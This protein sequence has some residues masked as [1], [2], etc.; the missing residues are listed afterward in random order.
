MSLLFF[1][2]LDGMQ[3]QLGVSGVGLAIERSQLSLSCPRMHLSSGH[4]S[5]CLHLQLAPVLCGELRERHQHFQVA[6]PW[7]LKGPTSQNTH[8]PMVD[9]NK[10]IYLFIFWGVGW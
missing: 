3:T 7:C 4:S 10:N 9:Q 1:I 5:Y 8:W 6:W 2:L